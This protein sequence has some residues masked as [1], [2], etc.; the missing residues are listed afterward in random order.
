MI[1]IY[2]ILLYIINLL[3]FFL[4]KTR[5]IWRGA[6]FNEL[7]NPR[8]IS[9]YSIISQTIDHTPYVRVLVGSRRSRCLHTQLD[10][11]ILQLSFYS[12]CMQSCRA[13]TRKSL[14]SLMAIDLAMTSKQLHR[15][16]FYQWICISRK[17][18]N[19]SSIY[20]LIVD[21]IVIGKLTPQ[22]AYHILWVKEP[23][24]AMY[25]F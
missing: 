12:H 16:W 2:I 3:Y 24:M 5:P 14:Y 11:Y 4:T 22:I 8:I 15:R 21:L 18:S 6:I 20:L 1:S 23:Q 13:V 25:T 19:I 7:E 10:V 17:C 9:Y